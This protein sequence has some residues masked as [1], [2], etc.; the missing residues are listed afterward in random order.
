M[1]T[2]KELIAVLTY[3]AIY[4]SIIVQLI[5]NESDL[6]KMCQKYVLNKSGV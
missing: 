4:N 2:Y 1:Q 6:L 3:L 5:V